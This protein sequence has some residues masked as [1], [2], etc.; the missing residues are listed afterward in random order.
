MV[1]LTYR[2]NL[3]VTIRFSPA[4]AHSGILTTYVTWEYTKGDARKFNKFAF[5]ISR[6]IRLTPQLAI[7]ILCFFL[8]PL[9][10][11]G[12]M[13]KQVTE[14]KANVCYK[15]WAINL[16]YLQSYINSEKLVSLNL[17]VCNF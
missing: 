16:L 7:V 5:A 6:Y 17:Y 15:N 3:F 9:F 4:H 1:L 14:D 11:D 2:A 8:L 12:P 13:F 10:G